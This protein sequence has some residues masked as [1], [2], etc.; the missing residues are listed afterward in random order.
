MDQDHDDITIAEYHASRAR[1][2]RSVTA[3]VQARLMAAVENRRAPLVSELNDLTILARDRN[4]IYRAAVAAYRSTPGPKSAGLQKA[5]LKA[6][7]DYK[8][9]EAI[10][11][12]RRE[13]LDAIDRRLRV[14]IEQY[15]RELIGQLETPGGLESAFKRDPLLA[16]AHARMLAAQARRTVVLE[17]A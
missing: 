10:V 2:I 1:Y 13:A 3:D 9:L 4:D 6:A 7:A 12:K 8:E 16:R 5:A 15:G 14:E 11:K 17:S